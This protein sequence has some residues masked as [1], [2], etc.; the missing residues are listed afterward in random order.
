MMNRLGGVASAAVLVLAFVL[1]G[2]LLGLAQTCG[3][4]GSDVI[5]AAAPTSDPTCLIGG[6]RNDAQNDA[7]CCLSCPSCNRREASAPAIAS[8]GAVST[9]A[10]PAPS[11]WDFRAG[12]NDV[13]RPPL[14]WASSWSSRAPPAILS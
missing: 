2:P 6:E 10:A 8:L 4:H 5:R 1:Q 11:I 13:R 12:A 3:G 9:F 14:G 7:Q